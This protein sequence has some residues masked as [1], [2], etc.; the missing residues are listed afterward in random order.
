MASVIFVSFFRLRIARRAAIVALP[1]GEW[2]LSELSG[3]LPARP[4]WRRSAPRA[5]G[6]ARARV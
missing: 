5:R 2:H 1:R 4:L 6:H 3:Y